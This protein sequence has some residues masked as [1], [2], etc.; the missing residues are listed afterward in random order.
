MHESDCSAD[1]SQNM[2]GMGMVTPRVLVVFGT[3]PEAIKMAPLVSALKAEQD[4]EIAV[5]VSG[6]HREM[7]D[8]VLNDFNIVPDFD[9]NIMTPGQNLADI[10]AKVLLGMTQIIETYKPNIVIVH[11]DTSTSC[12]SA[13][14]AFYLRVPV[15]HVEAGLRTRDIFSPWPE[16]FNR[17]SIGLVTRLHFP[18]TNDA[19]NNL[20]SEGVDDADITIT[21]NTIVDA[22]HYIHQRL[23]LDPLFRMRSSD[24]FSGLNTAVPIILVTAHRRENLGDGI[25]RICEA[26]IHLANTRECQFVFPVHKNPLVQKMVQEMLSQ[27]EGIHLVEPLSYPEIVTLISMSHLILT[28][29]GGIQEEAA[30]LRKPCL[31]MR[32]TTE[33]PEL[34]QAGGA[35]LVG[36]DTKEIIDNVLRLLRDGSAYA[37]MQIKD[38]PFG[39][40]YA[41]D[42]IAKRLL[43]FLATSVDT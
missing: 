9:I 7:L 28:D 38:N 18:P 17:R 41:A 3:R 13:L 12:M 4:I 5:C 34:I 33:R 37:K 22:V 42:R 1:Y 15:A 32:D 39:D 21:G 43:T 8:Q 36:T 35:K 40:G 6:Q 11:G 2:K 27:R 20:L 31:V 26:I 25:E 30:S 23:S 16:E 29:S 24:K 10:S 14:A 19:C